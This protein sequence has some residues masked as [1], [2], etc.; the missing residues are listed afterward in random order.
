MPSDQPTLN[1]GW[2]VLRTYRG[3][4]LR[5]VAMPIGGIGTGT[6]SLGGRGDL[7]D[8]EIVNRPA[9]GF[10]PNVPITRNMTDPRA[11]LRRPR[12][13]PGPAGRHA[14]AGRRSRP[15]R[16]RGDARFPRAPPRPAALRRR[17]VPRRL[18]AGAAVLARSRRARRPAAR[19]L[20]PAHPRSRRRQ[21]ASR[22]R[23][24]LGGR[25]PVGCPRAGSP[26]CA[27]LANFIGTDG[28]HGQ[29][30]RNVNR[31]RVGNGLRGLDM[32]SDG[33]SDRRRAVG[34][35]GPHRARCSRS[36]GHRTHG[37]VRRALGRRA[38]RLLGRLQ[39]RRPA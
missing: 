5:R 6:V 7:R 2:P 29:P 22:G 34:H 3:E 39:R 12:S 28:K 30:K 13:G 17:V 35:A 11:L 26:V 4:R 20:Q 10:V 9:K 33:V 15:G 25:Q 38:A 32:R 19:S 18:S 23:A 8:W 36:D 31:W 14:T 37:L 27:A 24:P 21:R 1:P 16:L